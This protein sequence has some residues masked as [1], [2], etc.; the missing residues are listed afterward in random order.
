MQAKG[1]GPV[2]MNF[3]GDNAISRFRRVEAKAKRSQDR[4]KKGAHGL[5]SIILLMKGKLISP[6][7]IV[8]FCVQKNRFIL[9][10]RNGLCYSQRI[11][12]RF[13]SWVLLAL[14]WIQAA[15]WAADFKLTNGD[16]ISGEPSSINADGLVIRKDIGGF[17]ER[18]GW[19]RFTQE[20]LKLLLDNPTAKPFVEPF[21]EVP[22]EIK[23]RV[24]AQKKEIVVKDPPRLERPAAKQKFFPG[25]LSPGGFVV[26][27]AFFV[28]NLYAAFHIAQFR[29]R[30]VALV[31]GL[32]VILP[33]IAPI[34]FLLVP[35]GEAA[36]GPA[37]DH[38]PAAG[39]QEVVSAQAKV[40]GMQSSLGL[41]A[42]Q[43]PTKPGE[44]SAQQVYKRTEVNFDRKFF[45][46][47]FT[48][49]FRV[50]PPNPDMVLVIKTPKGEFVGRRISRISGNE[51]HLQLLRGNSEVSIAFGEI[52]EVQ[53]RHKDAKS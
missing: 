1:Y 27:A 20:S 6:L 9:P 19:G 7:K 53:V 17:T 30:P 44:S 36:A 31:V 45:E 47:T 40:E 5:D 43:K 41:A 22:V 16:V 18:Y 49:Y 2:R 37:M 4:K 10:N 48:G 28:A 12:R 14:C 29:A 39:H 35:D 3:G 33:V 25:L 15:T 26:L 51:L 52:S 11:M 38:A 24:R 46:T 32:S 13:Y 50:V 34:I 8:V 21:I 23:E 42:H